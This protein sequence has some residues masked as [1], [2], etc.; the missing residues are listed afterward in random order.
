MKMANAV[1]LDASPHDSSPLSSRPFPLGALPDLCRSLGR[2]LRG[3]GAFEWSVVTSRIV[4][5]LH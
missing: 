4:R 2:G 1:V 5:A 3:L